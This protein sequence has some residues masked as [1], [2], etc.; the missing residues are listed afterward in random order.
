ME[1]CPHCILINVCRNR[2]EESGDEHN[3]VVARVDAKIASIAISMD[4]LAIAADKSLKV[5]LEGF[6]LNLG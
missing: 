4:R 2:G 1:A 6:F 3:D 5:A